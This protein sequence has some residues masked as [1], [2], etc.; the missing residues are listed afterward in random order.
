MLEQMLW[1]AVACAALVGMPALA[2]AAPD[3]KGR[4]ITGSEMVRILQDE[5]YR[6]QLDKD[7]EG[8]PLV[9]TG[10]SGLNTIVYFYD[11]EDGRCGSLKLSVGID[12]KQG[13]THA[14][15]NRFTR[16]YRYART[17]LDD[18][19]DPFIEFDFEVLH[20]NHVAHVTSQLAMFEQLLDAFARA[21]GFRD[22]DKAGD[23]PAPTTTTARATSLA[24]VASR[25]DAA[26]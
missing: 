13:S 8:D 19:E 16:E 23:A 22:A 25:S 4:G 3:D 20:A 21:V 5:G 24:R 11:C 18:E 7:G 1:R 2:L 10:M 14:V 15:L 9:R 17:F 6:A 12:L 26:P